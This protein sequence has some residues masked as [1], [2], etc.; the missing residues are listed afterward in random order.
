VLIDTGDAQIF[1]RAEGAGEPLIWLHG[2]GMSSELWRAQWPVFTPRYRCVAVDL[3]GFGQSSKPSAA[4]A[5][6]IDVLAGDIAAV[7]EQLAL[8]RCHVLG[9]SMGGFIAQSLALARPE[10]CRSLVLC[11]TAPHMSI[12][13]DVL[14]TRLEALRN[15]PLDEYAQLVVA[16][17]CSARASAELRAWVASMLAR[18]DQRAYTQVL[19]EGL[20]GFDVRGELARLA[21][22][23]LVVVGEDDRVLPPGG[24]R[25]L[26]R[27]IAGAELVELSGVGHLGYAE[28]PQAFN[29]SVLAFLDG[30]GRC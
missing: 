15:Q 14:A 25:E 12:P 26:A 1:V 10:L 8:G 28:N 18:N 24:G 20:S 2:L 11:H 27:L 30:L 5:Y 23:T 7:I 29:R 13:A 6:A 3:R 19:S 21:L 16:Q 17:A 4:G 9:T 22:P